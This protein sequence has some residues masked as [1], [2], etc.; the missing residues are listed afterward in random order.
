MHLQKGGSLACRDHVS[1]WWQSQGCR[2]Q[3]LS[4]QSWA[5]QERPLCPVTRVSLRQA[6]T[7]CDNGIW[8]WALWVAFE[9]P[10][11]SDVLS[12]CPRVHS[13][14]EERLWARGG[15]GWHTCQERPPVSSGS[16]VS[17]PAVGAR[18]LSKHQ[19]STKWLRSHIVRSQRKVASDPLLPCITPKCPEVPQ[20][21]QQETDR[22]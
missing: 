12:L 16:T 21:S 5:G 6:T 4:P 9:A 13:A 20:P 10:P 15:W 1:S 18:I 11:S 17:Y 22:L 7:L 19:R 14:G 8:C 2:Q 3:V